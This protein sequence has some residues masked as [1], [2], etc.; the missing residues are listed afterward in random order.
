[1][2]PTRLLL[3]LAFVAACGSDAS[4]DSLATRR[5]EHT[6]HATAAPDTAVFVA[7]QAGSAVGTTSA[8]MQLRVAAQD[9]EVSIENVAGQEAMTGALG[10]D[11]TEDIPGSR[12][13]STPVGADSAQGW[14]AT[15]TIPV[16]EGEHYLVDLAPSTPRRDSA[17]VEL[18]ADGV[19]LGAASA[20]V[21][22]TAGESS[23]HEIVVGQ[24]TLT[25]SPAITRID[26][27]P[28]CGTSHL[29]RSTGRADL[30]AQ[31]EV[32]E[33]KEH[34]DVH[35]PPRAEDSQFRSVSFHSWTR[36]SVR[37]TYLGRELATAA[38][39]DACPDH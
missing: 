12:A 25:V 2:T 23:L 20:D 9:A 33:T 3:P 21:D 10:S 16:L 32:V 14:R 31:Y 29:L 5:T 13:E 7:R 34:G 11:N 38:R 36:G 35:I 17:M 18:T 22:A 28:T 27:V 19:R 39:P 37:I 6:S 30:Y 8:V 1:M 26:L 24:H 4:R 15:V